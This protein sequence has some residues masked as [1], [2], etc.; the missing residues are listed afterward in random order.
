M[1]TDLPETREVKGQGTQSMQ[2]LDPLARD[3][4]QWA[5]LE[6]GV[7]VL[8]ARGHLE[9][10]HCHSGATDPVGEILS[11]SVK[12]AIALWVGLSSPHQNKCVLSLPPFLSTHL[13]LLLPCPLLSASAQW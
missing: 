4:S 12:A 8:T 5:A 10:S 7:G 13:L 6:T 2:G 3:L 1:P 9:I 11:S